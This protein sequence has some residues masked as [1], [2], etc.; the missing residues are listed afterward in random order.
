MDTIDPGKERRVWDRV[1]GARRDTRVPIG[2]LYATARDCGELYV[3]LRRESQGVLARKCGLLE[4]Q[5]LQAVRKLAQL[6]DGADTVGSGT[7][8][9]RCSQRRKLELAL[10]WMQQWTQRCRE[11]S[12]DRLVGRQLADLSQLGENHCRLLRQLLGK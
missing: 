1:Y 9:P 7:G 11:F 12:D 4:R 2:Q 6:Y 3:A 10:R 5:M 8:C